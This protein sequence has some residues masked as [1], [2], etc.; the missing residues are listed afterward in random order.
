MKQPERAAEAPA[1]RDLTGACAELSYKEKFCSPSPRLAE[2]K[3]VKRDL[4]ILLR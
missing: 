4:Y 2:G 1:V 3:D